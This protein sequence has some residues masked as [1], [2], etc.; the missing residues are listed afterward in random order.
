MAQAE[1]DT[2][3]DVV[4]TH[5]NNS[6][7]ILQL[8]VH[9]DEV[10]DHRFGQFIGLV[11]DQ[12]RCVHLDYIVQDQPPNLADVVSVRLDPDLSCDLTHEVAFLHVLGTKDIEHF[13]MSIRV[14][15]RRC[16]LAASGLTVDPCHVAPAL[17]I[18]Q[19]ITDFLIGGGL[20]DLPAGFTFST[21][22]L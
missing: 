1:A 21:A 12:K 16:S 9:A 22:Y 10:V 20:H 6:A 13:L 11:E 7:F 3:F 4:S 8:V 5:K 17:G 14:Q 15:P 2:L 18:I 19:C